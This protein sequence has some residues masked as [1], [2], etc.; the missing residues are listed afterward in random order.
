MVLTILCKRNIFAFLLLLHCSIVICSVAHV[1]YAF[2]M[3]AIKLNYCFIVVIY[4]AS[5][6]LLF[7]SV[8]S[9][10][11]LNLY[12]FEWLFGFPH[13]PRSE[14]ILNAFK[15]DICWWID[16]HCFLVLYISQENNFCMVEENPR[17][18][19]GWLFWWEACCCMACVTCGI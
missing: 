12:S 5:H 11:I 6:W 10:V 14:T 18:F 13:I 3:F 8:Q 17:F 9:T 15:S 1:V 19:L 4:S 7:S 16:K 2:S